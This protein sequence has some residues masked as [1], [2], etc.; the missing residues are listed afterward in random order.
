VVK[1]L[2]GQRSGRATPIA[3]ESG[4]QSVNEKMAALTQKVAQLKGRMDSFKPKKTVKKKALASNTGSSAKA[5][6]RASNAGSTSG[7]DD[8]VNISMGDPPSKP[9]VVACIVPIHSCRCACRC[10]RKPPRLRLCH[11]V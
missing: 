11:R 2:D 10:L 1:V 3:L 8:D 7:R 9:G 6:D 5:S 4:R